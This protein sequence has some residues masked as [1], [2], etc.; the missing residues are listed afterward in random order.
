MPAG[1]KLTIIPQ[2]PTI[3]SGTLRS[4]LDIFEDYED[5]EIFEAL[6]RVHLIK[7]NETADDAEEGANRSPFF[8]L[9]SEVSEGGGNYSQGQRQLLCMA[10]ALLKRNRLLLLDEATAS[11]DYSAFPSCTLTFV[12]ADLSSIPQKRMSSFRRPSEKSSQSRLCSSSLV[13]LFLC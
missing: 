6:R 9:D 13:S 12:Y 5:I 2:D 1:S 11:V 3:L 10:R 8:D 4:T 7:P